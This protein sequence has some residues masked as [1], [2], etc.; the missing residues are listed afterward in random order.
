MPGG[1]T[2]DDSLR[3]LLCP[4]STERYDLPLSD[5]TQAFYASLCFR[6]GRFHHPER[7]LGNASACKT[8]WDT[9]SLSPSYSQPQGSVRR[10]SVCTPSGETKLID[11]PYTFYKCVYQHT[12][13]SGTGV[14]VEGGL[15]PVKIAAGP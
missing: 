11:A 9:K 10:P 14:G 13:S 1:V 7:P 8:I 6:L 15:C 4:F 12:E 2:A 5:C 3:S